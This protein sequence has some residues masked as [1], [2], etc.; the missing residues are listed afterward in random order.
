MNNNYGSI[1][2]PVVSSENGSFPATNLFTENRFEAW[3]AAGNFTI[4]S[5]NNKL[6]VID[7][8][9]T[10]TITLT[11]A[12]YSSTSLLVE[13]KAKLDAGTDRTWTI[14]YSSNFDFTLVASS[15]S[16][17][18]LSNTT[19]SSWDVLGFTSITNRVGT[20]FLADEIRIHTHE[21]MTWDFSVPFEIGFLAGIVAI[22]EQIKISSS[23]TIKLQGSNVANWDTPPFDKT[24]SHNEIA[25]MD[26]MDDQSSFQYRYWRFYIEDKD[27]PIGPE[28][29]SF[30]H[31]YLGSYITI[32]QSNIGTGFVKTVL[33][34]SRKKVSVSGVEYYRL[35]PKRT[36][37]SGLSIAYLLSDDR[38]NIEQMFYDLGISTPLYVSFDPTLACSSDLTELTKYVRFSNSPQLRHVLLDQYSMSL[39]LSEVI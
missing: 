23:A 1:V 6:Y 9:G 7:G 13:L 5:T 38:K 11:S 34:K 37:F 35:K 16:T 14:T 15:S 20:S 26:F 12:D 27:N 28:S 24:I 8:S 33:D 10:Q 17:L 3:K 30:G 32:T 21:Y 2:T 22:D 36:E 25:V 19:N 39:K 31:L 4:D 29:V 18:V